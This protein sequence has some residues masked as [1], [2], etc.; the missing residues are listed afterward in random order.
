MFLPRFVDL[1]DIFSTITLSRAPPI[2]LPSRQSYVALSG[3]LSVLLRL[4]L[5]LYLSCCSRFAF[6]LRSLCFRFA[7][8]FALSLISCCFLFARHFPFSLSPR[9]SPSHP[10]PSAP[11]R[12]APPVPFPFTFCRSPAVYL[13]L[14]PLLLFSHSLILPPSM[15]SA[16]CRGYL[17]TSTAVAGKRRPSSRWY[18]TACLGLRRNASGLSGPKRKGQP[19]PRYRTRSAGSE[20]E[21]PPPPPPPFLS[22]ICRRCCFVCWGG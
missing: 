14:P 6:A 3:A 19:R 15:F 1:L 8:T 5:S 4:L 18:G 2:P 10:A 9:P 20:R 13:L 11:P 7:S 16:S 22:N 17:V 21:E 12:P